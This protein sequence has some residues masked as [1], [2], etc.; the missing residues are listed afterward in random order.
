MSWIN[1]ASSNTGS[2][3]QPATS[4]RPPS[5]SRSPSL[6]AQRTN[7][8]RPPARAPNRRFSRARQRCLN[9]AAQAPKRCISVNLH[10][11]MEHLPRRQPVR[12]QR[13]AWSARRDFPP[14]SS[15]CGVPRRSRQ[16]GIVTRFTKIEIARARTVLRCNQ[17]SRDRGM[18]EWKTRSRENRTRCDCCSAVPEP[19]YWPVTSGERQ[20]QQS[21]AERGFVYIVWR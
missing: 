10:P 13:Q 11:A 15:H 17:R 14:L 8:L 19:A 4:N 21:P 16:P 7:S 1:P 12:C 2:T 5:I 20:K 18:L 6:K 9:E 3:T